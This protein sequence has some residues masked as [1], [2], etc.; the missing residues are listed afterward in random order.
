MMYPES[1][2][3]LLDAPACSALSALTASGDPDH[4]RLYLLDDD[5]TLLVS[6]NSARA[7]VRNIQEHPTVNVHHRPGQPVP[8]ARDPRH[9]TVTS[10]PDYA[11]RERIG[12]KYSADMSTFDPPGSTRWTIRITPDKVVAA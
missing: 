3:D 11:V 9:A 10:D 4:C 2:R 7:K 8:H 12:A 1:H 6:A 5:G